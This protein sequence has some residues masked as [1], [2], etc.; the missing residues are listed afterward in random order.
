MEIRELRAFIT[1]V[2]EGALSA[3]A[4]KMFMSQP[5][6]SATMQSLERQLGGQL[7]VRGPSGA[8]PTPLGNAL[9]GEARALVARHDRVVNT[10]STPP[11]A[12][13]AT[14]SVGVPLELPAG[15]LP[16]AVARISAQY[17]DLTVRLKHASG[18]A[19]LTALKAG[20][21]DAGLVRDRPPDPSIDSALAVLE[22]MGVILT[23][24][25]SE[26]FAEPTGIRLHR[27]AGLR[28][29]EF[30]RA[31]APAWHDQVSATLRSHGVV[32]V[33][34]AAEQNRPVT[35]EVKLAAAGTG[36]AFALAA[37]GWARPLPDGLIW[38]RLIGNPLMRHTWT[39][40]AAES[41]RR[42]LAC[43]IDALDISRS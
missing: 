42:D 32:G 10:L 40:W 24:A 1:V 43:L 19:Q 27:L 12:E 39:I 37:E 25:L 23:A 2:E 11:D 34:P 6:L 15:L 8:R 13:R 7:L 26:Q 29:V 38:Q 20:E 3:A 9:L 41:K 22:P 14:L 33:D 4:R 35:Q 31:D 28:W 36:R 17:P 5:A 21:L 18:S 30:A 16:G